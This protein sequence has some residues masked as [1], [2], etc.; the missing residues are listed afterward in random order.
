MDPD[1]GVGGG[2][3]MVDV[4]IPN[5]NSAT[6]ATSLPTRHRR[7]GTGGTDSIFGASSN[8]MN[9]IV[10]AGIIGIPYALRQSGIVVGILLL[11][12]VAYLTDKSLRMMMECALF[13]PKLRKC[14][15]DTYESLIQIPFGRIG[16]RF[17]LAS[18]FIMAYG[19]MIAYLIII[20][21]TIPKVFGLTNDTFMDKE[22]I[23]LV[24][25]VIVVLPLSLLRDISMLSFTSAISVLADVLLVV[26][27]IIFSPVPSTIADYDGDG[28]GG[29]IRDFWIAPQLFIGL[30][31][32]STAMSCQHSA[33]L[34][35]GSLS[36]ITPHRWSIVT[37][38]SLSVATIMTLLLG[39]FGFLGYLSETKG[40]SLGRLCLQ[41]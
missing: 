6:A 36:N 4:H 26:I 12:L 14:Q 23:M 30:G 19:A 29:I 2:T 17:I 34:I 31:V 21:D 32:L 37:F 1:G 20:K 8:L 28:L 39:V 9:S 7:N 5:T 25:A 16:Y 38:R 3:G 15:V 41:L 10:G 35:S 22:L 24:S 18:M 11:A 40:K 27:I 33:F 13:H